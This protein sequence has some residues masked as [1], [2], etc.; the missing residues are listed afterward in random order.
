MPRHDR[1]GG[2]LKDITR[3]ALA[4]SGRLAAWLPELVPPMLDFGLD[5]AVVADELHG[6]V[7]AIDACGVR[8]AAAERAQF[9]ARQERVAVV[10]DV[11]RWADLVRRQLRILEAGALTGEQRVRLPPLRA[12]LRSIHPSFPAVERHL[13]AAVARVEQMPGGDALARLATA[14]QGLLA[15][16]AAAQPRL[17]EADVLHHE[18]TEHHRAL[19]ERL[20][21]RVREVGHQWETARAATD[22]PVPPVGWHGTPR[23]PT[24]P[25]DEPS[26]G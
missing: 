25:E 17:A 20:E 8:R 23:R 10:E 14:G 19:V 13:P 22:L 3:Q 12:L 24:P 6:L 18:L 5:P 21:R 7:Q 16:M 2:S 4:M 15:R 11:T 1:F 9:E 26:E